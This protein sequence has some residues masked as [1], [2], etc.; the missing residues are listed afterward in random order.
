MIKFTSVAILV[1]PTTKNAPIYSGTLSNHNTLEIGFDDTDSTKGMCTTFLA[2]KIVNM[3]KGQ[4]VKFLDFPRLIRFNP[5]I[6][7]KTRGNGAVS[8]RI[9][10]DDPAKVKMQVR[11]MVVRYS[12]VENGANPG[13]VFIEGRVPDTLS[14]FSDLA[15]WRLV[16]RQKARQLA[17]ENDMDFFYM[18]NGQGLVGA[19]GAIGYSFDDHTL[20]LLSYRKESNFGKRRQISPHSVRQI[21][22]ENSHTFNSFD[23]ESGKVLIAPHGPDPVFYGIRGED[24]DSLLHAAGILKTNERP[25]GHM[26]FKSNQGTGDHMKNML[27]FAD[28][29]PYMSGRIIGTVS[30]IPETLVGGHVF[31]TIYFE[32]HEFRCAVYKPTGM[33]QIAR[34]LIPGDRICVGG[35]IRKAS[36]NFP[37][38]L[39]VEFIDVLDLKR[40]TIH[41]N[42]ICSRCTKAMKSKGIGQGYQCTRCKKRS[43]QKQILTIPRKVK[44]RLYVPMVSAYRH[45]ARP[46]QRIGRK[47]TVLKFNESL[48]WIKRY[49]D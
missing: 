19:I 18:G 43:S 39:N 12:D 32:G 4:G 28:I 8:L 15:L 11:D 29:G 46:A 37:R 45:L 16:G 30:T 27:E 5:N 20:E 26:I 17:A 25:D 22:E 33:T 42:P 47:N 3:L 14:R 23:E 38:V 24:I 48:P 21:Q 9:S 31:F 34:G 36:K 13:L 49:R 6:P 44:K 1:N 35:G 41:V 7:W 40:H 10:V 2:Y